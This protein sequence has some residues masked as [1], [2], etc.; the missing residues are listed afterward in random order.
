[1]SEQK[2]NELYTENVIIKTEDDSARDR[3]VHALEQCKH[4][5][6][7]AAKILGISRKTLFN[8]MKKLG[9]E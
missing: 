6:T 1:M 9:L 3:I 7:D 5:K 2:I 4:S 8:R